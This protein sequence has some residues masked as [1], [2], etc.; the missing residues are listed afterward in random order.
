MAIKVFVL[1]RFQK[2]KKTQNLKI[3]PPNDITVT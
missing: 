2:K 3:I 1:T